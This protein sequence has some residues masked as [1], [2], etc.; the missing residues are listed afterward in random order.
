[1][2]APVTFAE[3]EQRLK[4]ATKFKT[5]ADRKPGQ[6]TDHQP[7]TAAEKDTEYIT[8]WIYENDAY[9]GLEGVLGGSYQLKYTTVGSPCS[10]KPGL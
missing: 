10:E 8:G 4:G 9:P 5:R 7:N 3:E 6:Y 2:E 1:M